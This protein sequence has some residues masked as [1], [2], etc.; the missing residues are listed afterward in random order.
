MGHGRKVNVYD[1]AILA[2]VNPISY[3][4][5][6]AMSNANNEAVIEDQRV[7]PPVLSV[8]YVDDSAAACTSDCGGQALS[9]PDI[10]PAIPRA[11][12]GGTIKVLPGTYT[13]N[14]NVN[15][16]LKLRGAAGG[17]F[18]TAVS[19]APTAAPGVW[20]VDRYAPAVFESYN[21][22]GRDGAAARRPHRRLCC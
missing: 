22:D 14:V 12:T 8:V 2:D 18:S 10:A 4:D 19:T 20:Y 17:G 6:V 3:T 16:A 9:V 1:I 11:V 7:S 15:K 13:E 5:I 21:F